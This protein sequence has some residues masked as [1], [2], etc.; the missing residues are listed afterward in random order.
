[1]LVAA[2]EIHLGK[3]T[4]PRALESCQWAF[5]SV[6]LYP[7][8]WVAQLLNLGQSKHIVALS[9]CVVSS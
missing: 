7:E 6:G 2:A 4:E 9:I 5:G 1:M 8:A 3:A